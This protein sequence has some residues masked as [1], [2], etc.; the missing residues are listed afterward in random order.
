MSISRRGEEKFVMVKSYATVLLLVLLVSA[1]VVEALPRI[2]SWETGKGAKV[3][4]VHAPELPM[5]DIR[6][7]FRAGAARDGE[8][9]GIAGLTNA[10][11]DQGAGGLSADDIARGMEQYGAELDSGSERDMAWLSLRS[12][13]DQKLLKPALELFRTVL[14][15]PDFPAADFEREQQR[16]LVGLQYEKQK[17]DAITKKSFYLGLYQRHP[18]ANHPSGSAETV[19]ALDVD[20]L[21]S[22][23]ERHY[24]A[25]N[26]TVVIVGDLPGKQAR[27]IAAMLADSLEKGQRSE[28]LPDVDALA[29][30]R[31]LSIDF[32][33]KQSHV[34]TG[35]PGMRRGDP[36]YF[37]LYVGNHIL[38]GSGLVSRISEEIR[39]KRGLSYSAYSYFIPMERKGPYLLGFQTR[40]DQRQAAL[41][42]L[43]DTLQAFIDD[44]PTAEE[45]DAAK[46]NIIGGFPLK[47]SSNSKIAEYLAVIG[48]YD[49]PLDYLARF[50]EKVD[51]VTVEQ[52]QDAYRRRIDP[53]RMLT[54]MVGGAPESESAQAAQ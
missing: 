11:L 42:V 35:Q 14:S 13:T 54:V 38:G 20:A 33:S 29:A 2:E 6:L 23:Y 45:L 8:Q 50:T 25:Q 52:I 16:T 24:V 39:E 32:P 10:M 28:P 9:G 44:G 53:G 17:P 46:K 5:V 51:A 36:D 30:A 27:R 12:L 47:V 26:A 18:Y 7:V 21:R 31:Q 22:F 48:F 19:Q 43:R 41:Q 40:N 37:P 49:L 1:S 15:Q 3:L 34:L 4:F